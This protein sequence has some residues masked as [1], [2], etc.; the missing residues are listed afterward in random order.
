MENVKTKIIALV[1]VATLS[2][3]AGTRVVP[4]EK[5][6]YKDKIVTEVE[7]R[8][9]VVTKI[10]ERP[11]G[12]KETIII[13]DE[14]TNTTKRAVHEKVVRVDPKWRIG[15]QY[16][17]PPDPIYGITIERYVLGNL[18][19]GGFIRTNREVGLSLSVSF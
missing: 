7:D 4:D 16:S 15:V 9:R 12:D 11:D 19:V 14:K 1:V 13:R 18:S 17:N 8:V 6:V 10:K 3:W 2:F 5:I